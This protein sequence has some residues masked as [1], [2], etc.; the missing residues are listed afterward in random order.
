M[1]W[2]AEWRDGHGGSY[3]RW[4]WRR[5][6]HATMEDVVRALFVIALVVLMLLYPLALMR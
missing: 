2:Q 3:A 4:L 1:K 5:V 6:R